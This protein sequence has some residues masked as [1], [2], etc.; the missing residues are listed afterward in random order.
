MAAKLYCTD[1]T[2]SPRPAS[3]SRPPL[4]DL[5]ARTGSGCTSASSRALSSAGEAV[6]MIARYR[7]RAPATWGAAMLVP[8][9]SM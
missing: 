9:T 2:E 6:G 7:A 8:L 5:P 3:D 4:T 1:A